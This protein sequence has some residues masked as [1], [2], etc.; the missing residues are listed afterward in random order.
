[1][2]LVPPLNEADGKDR[3]VG[4]CETKKKDNKELVQLDEEIYIRKDSIAEIPNSISDAD[5]ISTA[6]SALA[7]VRCTMPIS[8]DESHADKKVV[9]L[10]GG[11]FACFIAKALNALG[12]KVTLVTTRPMSLKDTPLN[13]LRN[14]NSKLE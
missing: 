12:A 5:A 14:T 1:M 6:T 7:G 13:P 3:V 11:D 9:V 10:G 4:I 8:L 2:Q